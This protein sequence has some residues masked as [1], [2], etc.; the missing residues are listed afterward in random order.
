[1]IV[2]PPHS[3]IKSAA[4]DFLEMLTDYGKLFF[5]VRRHITYS[6]L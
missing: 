1:M 5:N 3:K 2:L 4:T 6:L